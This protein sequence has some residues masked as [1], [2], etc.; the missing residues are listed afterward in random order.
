MASI[1]SSLSLFSLMSCIHP[2]PYWRL[3]SCSPVNVIWVAFGH[4]LVDFFPTRLPSRLQPRPGLTT[5][6]DTAVVFLVW[7]HMSPTLSRSQPF[8]AKKASRQRRSLL[9]SSLVQSHIC[10]PLAPVQRRQSHLSPNHC[11]GSFIAGRRGRHQPLPRT[12]PAEGGGLGLS[13]QPFPILSSCV[14]S[15]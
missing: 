14:P 3:Q 7:P 9:R 8:R 6:T 2:S 11:H 15:N 5:Q 12:F 10:R 1:V 4:P 13:R